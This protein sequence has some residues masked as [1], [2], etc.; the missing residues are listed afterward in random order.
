MTHRSLFKRLDHLETQ[1]GQ[2][3]QETQEEFADRMAKEGKQWGQRMVKL[4]TQH[5]VERLPNESIIMWF[6]RGFGID[7]RE[8]QQSCKRGV[9]EMEIEW[10]NRKCR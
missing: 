7:Y 8:F 5:G 3:G 2:P 6:C 9:Q 10:L 1:F 4:L